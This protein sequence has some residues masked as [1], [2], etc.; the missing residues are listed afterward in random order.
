MKQKHKAELFFSLLGLLLFVGSMVVITNQ[1]RKYDFR[2]VMI[3]L[4]SIKNN[5]LLPALVFTVLSYLVLSVYDILACYHIRHPLTY[6]KVVLAAFMGHAMSNSVGFA[7]LTSSAVRYRLYSTWGLS[8][9]EIAQVIAFSNLSF[10][11]GLFAV[12]G[13][14]FILKPVVIPTLLHLPFAS[15]HPLGLIFLTL[16]ISYFLGSFWLKQPLKIWRWKISF[17]SPKLAWAQMIVAAVDWLLAAG[18][19]YVLLPPETNLSY[20]DFFS[21]Y[22]LAQ[23]AG[24]ISH[25]PGGLGVFETII[26]LFFSSGSNAAQIFGTLLA[27]R[28]IYY[29]LPLAVAM[30]LLGLYEIDQWLRLR[31]Q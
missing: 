14:G 25:V 1:L 7:L 30:L 17:P 4:E 5:R 3:S 31:Q 27:Y 28:V 26:L 10:W 15:A 11:L 23:I 29:L 16:V 6:P 12:G 13:I 8:A 9:V 21:I 22:L 20:L 24:I 18:V 19:L 2:D